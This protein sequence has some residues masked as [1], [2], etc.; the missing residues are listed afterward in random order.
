M[1]IKEDMN[2]VNC[3]KPALLG[4]ALLFSSM[5]FSAAYAQQIR[6]PSA[7]ECAAQAE[8]S[9]AGRDDTMGEVVGGA[10]AGLFLGGIVGDS[11]SAAGTGALIGALAGGVR[12]SNQRYED[13]ER[14]YRRCMYGLERMR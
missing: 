11:S 4:T 7:S 13:Y 12:G 2:L 6:T 8:R 3:Y 5:I 1:I 10:T 14:A 9:A